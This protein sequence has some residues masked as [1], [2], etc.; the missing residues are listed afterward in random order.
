M[1][2]TPYDVINSMS[3]GGEYS[4]FRGYPILAAMSQQVEYANMHT[5]MADEMTR[6]WI[7]VKSTKEGDPDIDLMDLALTKYDI[8]RLIH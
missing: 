7:E 1:D 5:I 4:G 8:K 6:N 2:S 3:I